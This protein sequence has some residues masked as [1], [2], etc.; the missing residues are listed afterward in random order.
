[1]TKA[2][3]CHLLVPGLFEA[4]ERFPQN[5]P[6]PNLDGILG[7]ARPGTENSRGFEQILCSHFSLSANTGKDLPTGALSLLGDGG[8]PGEAVWANIAPALEYNVFPYEESTHRQLRFLYGIGPSFRMYTDSTIY[9]EIQENLWM[10]QL[11]VAY[12]VQEKWGSINLS[13]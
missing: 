4:P 8:N 1:M 9:D 5:F 2:A 11:Q 10:H 7:H 12:Q 3:L 6:T 13:L